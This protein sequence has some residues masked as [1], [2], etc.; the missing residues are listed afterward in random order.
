MTDR[1]SGTGSPARRFSVRAKLLLAFAG[2][3]GMTVG[4]SFVGLYSYSAVEAPLTRIVSVSLPEMDLAKRLSGESGGI[5]AAAPTLDAADSQVARGQTYT[6]IMNRGRQLMALVNELGE[7]RPDD[8]R[9]AEVKARATALIATLDTANAAVDRRLTASGKREMGLSQLARAREY[10]LDTL[11]PLIDNVGDRLRSKGESLE[12]MTEREIEALGGAVSALIGMYEIRAD[13][14]NL[15]KAAARAAASPTTLQVT[16]QQQVYLEAAARLVSATLHA[17]D[18]LSKETSDAI[19]AFFALGDGA[20]GVFDLRRAALE[21]GDAERAA[22][23]RRVNAKLAEVQRSEQALLDALD[24]I[25]LRSR[26]EIKVAS[27]NIRTETRESMREV[28]G[29]GLSSFRTYLELQ[30]SANLLT[31]ALNEAAQAR[32]A[33]R[34]DMMRTRFDG[35]LGALRERMK[36]VGNTGDDAELRKAADALAAFGNGENSLFELRRAELAA[37]AEGAKVLAET[38]TLAAQFAQAVEEQVAAMKADAD[39]AAADAAQAIEAG[40]LL[41]ILF[42]VGSLVGGVALAW[43][44]VGRTIVTRIARLAGAMRAIAGGNLEAPIPQGGA[45]EITDMAQALVVFRDTA[46]EAAEANAR[47]ETE[48]TRATQERRRAMIEMAETF[49]SSVRGMLDRVSR[50]ADEMHDVAERMTRT[51]EQTTGEAATAAATSQQA[52]GS[53]EAV[54]AATEE[55]SASIQEIGTQVNASSRIARQA[56]ADAERTDHTVEGLSHTAQK[57]GEV[58]QLINDIASQTNLLALNATIE[59]ARAGEA[60]KGFAVVASEVKNLA[61]QTGKATEEISGQIAA[62]QSVTQEAVEAIRSIAGTIRSINDIAS[63][64]AAAV[65]QQSAATREIARNVGE[66]ADGTRHVR[67]NIDSVARAAAESGQSANRV[68]EASTTVA[69]EVRS[70]GSQVNNFVSR[71]R[72]G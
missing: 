55:L 33:G 43:F 41:M 3:A 51:A 23:N 17:G 26:A 59:A 64:I 27:I 9:L 49:E 30:T 72:A 12:S 11:Q 5:A 14:M 15:S 25:T 71:M 4:A 61:T 34:L 36:G 70:L 48:R 2:I 21:A 22:L 62:M 31:G 38:R 32:D 28:L 8:P 18:R 66:A 39:T 52:A 19:D 37:I 13:I 6:Q 60:G 57:I 42:A 20:D 58:V 67:E 10:F 65:E 35:V 40:R 7:R 63:A 50:A 53:V 44:T 46:R 45:D 68:L 47:A 56:A 1:L 16:N 29:N 69:D 24:P 54:A